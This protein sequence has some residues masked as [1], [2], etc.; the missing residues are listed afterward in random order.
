[1]PSNTI[2]FSEM[3]PPLGKEAEFNTWYD[4]HH[5]PIRMAVP[6]FHGT[7][8]YVREGSNYLAVYDMESEET[9]ASAA[10]REV[11]KNPNEQSK[12]MLTTV[13]GFSRYICNQINVQQQQ[14][15]DIN[16]LEASVLYPVFFKVPED[17]ADAFNEWYEQDH[18]PILLKNPDWLM[19]RR[20]TIAIAEPWDVTHLALHYLR[21][22]EVL[23]CKERKEARA[24]EWRARLAKESWFQGKYMMFDKV[25]GRFHP[26]Y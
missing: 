8:R 24:T 19:C 2:L 5:I 14:N 1:M 9:L 4:T 26:S 15:L 17:R 23:D 10:Y 7:Q 6:G 25:G 16:P 18:V 20:F 11:K 12:E 21:N 13:T 3:T 22:T